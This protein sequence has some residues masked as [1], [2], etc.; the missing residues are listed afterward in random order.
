M[1]QGSGGSELDEREVADLHAALDDEYKARATYA[2]VIEDFGPVRPFVNIV[3]AEGRHVAAIL[4]LFHR[5]GL[6][7]PEDPWPG[8]VP[9][10][11]SP[12]EACRAGVDAEIENGALYDRL[13]AG[14]TRPDVLEVY[15]NLQR[16]SQEHH[17][18]AFRRCVGRGGHGP[19]AG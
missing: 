9:R 2:R 18:P 16:A 1:A 6:P 12:A 13:L 5:Y 19:G 7:V 4:R 8:A 15:R 3:E 10:Y 11:G 14:T 17:L